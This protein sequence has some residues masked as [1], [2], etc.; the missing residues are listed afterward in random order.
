MVKIIYR[1]LASFCLGVG[2]AVM[3]L[4]P[5]IGGGFLVAG[6]GFLLLWVEEIVGEEMNDDDLMNLPTSFR[7][8]LK[9]KVKKVDD[10]KGLAKRSVRKRMW[11]LNPD[12]KIR[13]RSFR[14]GKNG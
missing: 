6:I 13:N 7:M 4:K 14:F 2:I 1:Q 9:P 8:N 10:L 12:G 5:G 11:D 3:F